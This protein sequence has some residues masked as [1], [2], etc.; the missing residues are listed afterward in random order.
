MRNMPQSW[1]ADPSTLRHSGKRASPASALD[2]FGAR[3]HKGAAPTPAPRLPAGQTREWN[4]PMF[5]D[6]PASDDVGAPDRHTPE[7]IKGDAL[8]L[9]PDNIA[10]S[11]YAETCPSCKGRG[12]F[13]SYAGRDCGPCF[14]CKG[15]GKMTFKT[16]PDQRAKARERAQDAKTS[17]AQAFQDAYAVELTYLASRAGRWE[18]AQAML[19][20][21]HKYNGWTER[22]LAAIRAAM[23]REVDRAKTR[24][25]GTPAD[26]AKVQASLSAALASGL[27]YPKLRLSD[28]VFS[29]AS[30]TSANAG[31]V[32]VKSGDTYLGKVAQGRFIG[33]RDCNPELAAAIIAAAADPAAAAK[34]YGLQTGSCSCCGRELTDPVSVAAGIGPICASRFAF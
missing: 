7:G 11:G 33:S 2:M 34:A 26:V 29:L 17:A 12:R 23:A 31:A 8:R 1:T 25:T 18:F 13:I 5:D 21:G 3:A 15:R 6:F 28:F 16:S 32:Y 19:D 22:Q 4:L 10:V 9:N 20:A 27:K 24:A 14:K 30:Q